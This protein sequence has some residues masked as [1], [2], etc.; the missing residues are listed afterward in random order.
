[1]AHYLKSMS[2]ASPHFGTAAL[3]F[4]SD[5]VAWRDSGGGMRRREATNAAGESLDGHRYVV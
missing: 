5:I 4:S 1:M 3:R 2:G